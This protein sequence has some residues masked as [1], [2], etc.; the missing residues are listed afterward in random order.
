M[1]NLIFQNR[2]TARNNTVL[3][4]SG[5][6]VAVVLC[7]GFGPSAASAQGLA[8]EVRGTW[9]TTTGPDHI[10]SGFNTE[11][12]INQ[13]NA[14]GVNTVYVEAWKNGYTQYGSTAF[15]DLV[16]IDRR[17][18]LGSRSIL[19]ETG[20]A[21]HRNGQVQLAWFE[22]GFSPEFVGN[23][24]T[25]FSPMGQ[26]ARDNGWLLEDQAGQFANA[27]NG[28][29]WMNPA[30][31]E[32]RQFLIDITLDAIRTHDL[33]GIQFD[34]R[35][36]WPR[37]FGWDATT[38]A[39]YQQETGRSLPSNV[40]D[41]NFRAWRQSKVTQFAVELT[42]AVR[43]ERPD[44]HLSVSP[45]I[46]GFSDNNFNAKWSDWVEQ[47]L[48]DE[49]IPQVYRSDLQ[50]FRDTLPSNLQ[51]FIDEGR[52]DELVVGLRY[53][54]TGADTP[55]SV[56][57][58]KIIDVALAE[59]GDLAGHA[60]F[61]SKGLIDNAAAMTSFYGNQRDNP[62]FGPDW[63]PAALMASEVDGEWEV[64]VT[65]AE[66]YRVV[67]KIAGRWVEVLTDVFD[68]DTYTFNVAGATQ[69]ELLLDRRPVA[70]DT[71]FDRIVDATDLLTLS[72]FLGSSGGWQDADFNYDG[73]VDLIDFDLLAA[74]W[75][76]GVDPGSFES[77]DDAVR[78]LGLN[79][80][81]EPGSLAL[82]ILVGGALVNR[83][84]R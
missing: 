2:W 29:A 4:I 54:G 69:V 56:V 40:N 68:A 27:S 33:D 52:L 43:A 25:P 82:L 51:P 70:G 58:Q 47:G 72:T 26:T 3:K 30:V 37:E 57:Q 79:N 61:Y 74:N 14:V 28:F 13:L 35:L 67:A 64:Q 83:R 6:F 77:L 55:T 81:P 48:F 63:R 39:I 1:N 31:P 62:F 45:S 60:L 15:N 75:Q 66:Q 12:I 18:S 84:R 11:S 24:G 21:A 50:S 53:N 19:T 34:D 36:A 59:N 23:G 7:F 38:A 17:P 5:L 8:P 46:L 49:Y 20:I 44:L 71:D 22:Y 10:S 16:G 73:T 41:A 80:V 78:R 32:V 9:L 65:D 76:F 42:D